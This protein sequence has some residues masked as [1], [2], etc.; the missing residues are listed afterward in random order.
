MRV[1][2]TP[3]SSCSGATPA[4]CTWSR[5]QPTRTTSDC[6]FQAGIQAPPSR[7]RHGCGAPSAQRRIP[8][9]HPQVREV[10]LHRE[11]LAISGTDGI[12]LIIHHAEPGP[13]DAE[14]GAP[15][16]VRTHADREHLS[17]IRRPTG[18]RYS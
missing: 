12:T 5:V 1:R 4:S 11:R 18:G 10:R 15:G 13:A 14:A 17:R 6:G 9:D 8:F 7:V 2:T 3:T 16:L